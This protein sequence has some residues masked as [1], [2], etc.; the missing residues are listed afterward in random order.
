M[1]EETLD[2]LVMMDAPETLAMM[3]GPVVLE[4]LVRKALLVGQDS[5]AHLAILEV[6]AV[7]DPKETLDDP[8]LMEHLASLEHPARMVSPA[9]LAQLDPQANLALLD[10]RLLHLA[11]PDSPAHP[12][13]TDSPAVPVD[14]VHKDLK[15]PQANQ[16]A[17][18][19]LVNLANLVLSLVQEAITEPL[20]LPVYPE[21]TDSLALHRTLQVPL[22][23][24][25]PTATPEVQAHPAR[26]DSLVVQAA[27]AMMD[28]LV[29][30]ELPVNQV[31]LADP[32]MMDAPAALVP[33]AETVVLALLDHKAN[34]AIPVPQAV[35]VAQD[36]KDLLDPLEIQ[37][38][39][40][41]PVSQAD[42]VD[43]DRKAHK[44]LKDQLVTREAL[45]QL[46]SLALLVAQDLKV[47]PD[48]QDKPS[49]KPL[50]PQLTNHLPNNPATQRLL[51][52]HLPRAILSQHGQH[53]HRS[54][55]SQLL[56][57]HL[58]AH[59]SHLT[60]KSIDRFGEKT[61]ILHIHSIVLLSLERLQSCMITLP[62]FFLTVANSRSFT[63]TD[64]M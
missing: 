25:E 10:N 26:M 17:L 60:A 9:A 36:L 50:R 11:H 51:G 59:R 35:P 45:V 37:E 52:Q 55:G 8:V 7:P 24:L 64:L 22:A 14:Q 39:L 63:K 18:E 46:A 2:D 41:N 32:A 20:V 54:N 58:K 49:P 62:L 30:Q 57:L 40:D 56:R 19:L 3:V 44:D 43:P 29:V 15:D 21:K 61:T 42:L 6:P 34:Q 53:R 5:M 12:A 13:R 48:R 31:S 27:P 33:Q 47:Q 28:A 4:L 16:A 38:A 1:K 23:N